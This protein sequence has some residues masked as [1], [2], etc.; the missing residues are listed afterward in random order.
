MWRNIKEGDIL[1]AEDL[2]AQIDLNLF[3]EKMYNTLKT[4]KNVLSNRDKK[5]LLKVLTKYKSV[6]KEEVLKAIICF[7]IWE[8]NEAIS[9]ARR[10]GIFRYKI[11]G[12][13]GKTKA[14]YFLGYLISKKE[15][16]DFSEKTN[17][18][19]EQKYEFE[20]L[21]SFYNKAEEKID[22]EIENHYQKRIRKRIQGINFESSLHKELFAYID[23]LFFLGGQVQTRHD[24][25]T[26]NTFSQEEI[27]E[28]I[29]YL[30]FKYIEKY[31]ISAKKNYF[32]DASYIISNQIEKLI[33]F[34]C[35]I[36][37]VLEMELL[38]DF[39]DYEICNE[40]KNII[41][42]SKDETLEKSIRLVVCPQNI[43]INIII[44]I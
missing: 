25:N 14:K 15:V 4:E 12:N 9:Q 10:K 42:R 38:V 26:L 17:K 20:W 13:K 19:L 3:N 21:E 40:G 7:A 30:L 44:Y 2:M 32:V 16:L 1:N 29:S 11:F 37:Y 24:S 6:T 36:N 39:Y 5:H 28:G 35:Q 41:L 8:P 31:G 27:A 18:Y 23:M 33:L 43:Y 34:A 22:T